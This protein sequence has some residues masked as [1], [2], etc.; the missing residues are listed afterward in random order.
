MKPASTKTTTLSALAALALTAV[1]ITI[2][3]PSAALAVSCHCF[4]DREFVAD[5]PAKADPYLLA[6]A[7]NS[8]FAASMGLPKADVVRARMGGAEEFD[9]W[10]AHSASS[11]TLHSADKFTEIMAREK[12]WLKAL[13]ALGVD[14]EKLGAGFAASLKKGDSDEI[15][16]EKLVD[17]YLVK[18]FGIEQKTLVAL[19]LK[20]ATNAQATLALLLKTLTDADPVA[21]LAKVKSGKATWGLLFDD[22]GVKAGQVSKLII[23]KVSE[24]LAR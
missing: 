13:N 10:I 21:S 7:R 16:A 24:G 15:A 8:L 17:P 19:R 6:T 23:R 2:A 1:V 20:G 18:G 14:P 12:S 9:L 3:L 4:T 22:A 5:A 11:V